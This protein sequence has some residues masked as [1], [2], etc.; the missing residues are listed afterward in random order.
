MGDAI[1]FGVTHASE[2]LSDIY[3]DTNLKRK[4]TPSGGVGEFRVMVM[5]RIMVMVMVRV[6]VQEGIRK[7]CLLNDSSGGSTV[8]Y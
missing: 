8:L 6:R 4:S 1:I 7:R 5:V 3:P 2:A